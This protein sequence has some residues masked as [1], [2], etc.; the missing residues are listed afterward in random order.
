M[1]GVST[2]SGKIA[3]YGAELAEDNKKLTDATELL[4]GLATTFAKYATAI[5]MLAS[6]FA[7][8]GAVMGFLNSMLTPDPTAKILSAIREL[9]EQ[10][11]RFE[12]FMEVEL[13]ELKEDVAIQPKL[14]TVSQT[15]AKLLTIQKHMNEYAKGKDRETPTAELRL[16][17]DPA[18]LAQ[19]IHDAY[20]ANDGINP[21]LLQLLYDKT[22][23]DMPQLA[24]AIYQNIALMM[25]ALRAATLRSCINYQYD[26]KGQAPS[27]QQVLDSAQTA[28]EEICPLLA[29]FCDASR[30][31]L[32]K[33]KSELDDNYRRKLQHLFP[34]IFVRA[35]DEAT[36]SRAARTIVN[37]LK[38]YVQY[39]WHVLVYK[40]IDKG[41][42]NSL[43]NSHTGTFE[44]YFRQ[45]CKDA[46]ASIV[47]V[48][49]RAPGPDKGFIEALR[50]CSWGLPP[51][52]QDRLGGLRTIYGETGRMFWKISPDDLFDGMDLHQWNVEIN[53]Y[54]SH[55]PGGKL[56]YVGSV[57]PELNPAFATTATDLPG[58]SLWSP[59]HVPEADEDG[60]GQI[61]I[62]LVC[63]GEAPPKPGLKEGTNG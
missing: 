52:L 46:R 28:C 19:Q 48:K 23:G 33:C 10:M 56:L 47:V 49:S 30:E 8:L 7:A 6:A 22:Y 60:S 42:A 15:R 14:Q 3:K 36:H 12:T 53:E 37:T 54:A 59:L 13:E 41:Q 63:V 2:V 45:E 62:K 38:P 34:K 29:S 35:G 57:K 51:G 24:R 32:D 20:V 39:Q 1:N 40:D 26:H 55:F 27:E 50:Q 43:L 4:G 16:C 31:I 17:E 21:N 18:M 44:G 58:M 11:A 9:S 5:S 25:T 61:P